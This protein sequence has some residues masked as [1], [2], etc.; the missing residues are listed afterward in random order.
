MAYSLYNFNMVE[1]SNDFHVESDIQQLR[2]STVQS[3][4]WRKGDISYGTNL[5]GKI[6]LCRKRYI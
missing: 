2:W 3:L 1:S 6:L 4:R 5:F